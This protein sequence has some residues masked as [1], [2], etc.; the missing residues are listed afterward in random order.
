M[1]RLTDGSLTLPSSAQQAASPVRQALF[2]MLLARPEPFVYPSVREL[3]F[4][5][6]MREMTMNA[7]RA[8]NSSGARFASFAKSACNPAYWDRE[9]NGGFRLRP[10]RAPAD[11]IRDIYVNGPLYAFECATA[12]VI[13]F[14]K[15]VLDSIGETQ[16]NRLFAGTHLYTWDTDRDLGLRTVPTTRF[17]PGDCLYFDNPEVSPSTPQWQGENVIYMG[18]ERYYG[19]GIGIST[20]ERI[21]EVLNSNRR[22]GAVTSAYL[23]DQ[24]TRPDYVYLSQFAES[25]PI[26]PDETGLPPLTGD[27][28]IRAA[29]GTASY[30]AL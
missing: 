17:I 14:Y 9:P 19:H 27:V 25:N 8:L 4:E 15:A 22:P 13:V 26:R 3:N 10:D 12:I 18:G 5:L 7:A 28:P 30:L 24:A 6:R 20:A 1:I 16:Y 21:I 2:G 11:A 29:I 23:L